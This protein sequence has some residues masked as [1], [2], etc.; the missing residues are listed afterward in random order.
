MFSNNNNN[1]NNNHNGNQFLGSMPQQQ[2]QQ[3]QQNYIQ[4]QQFNQQQ[5]QH[6]N[7]MF[8][9]MDNEASHLHHHQQQQFNQ[10]GNNTSSSLIPSPLPL[11][12]P[13]SNITGSS[14]LCF[15][16]DLQQNIFSPQSNIPT[17]MEMLSNSGNSL[18]SGLTMFSNLNSSQPI[19]M[20]NSGSNHS[21]LLAINE[22][23]SEQLV[24]ATP[25]IIPTIN[26]PIPPPP[27]QQQ[28]QQQQQV[29]LTNNNNNNN[30]NNND[31]NNDSDNEMNVEQPSSNDKLV[32]VK[33]IDLSS[34][35][36]SLSEA[37]STISTNGGGGGG[38]IHIKKRRYIIDQ[39]HIF[40]WTPYCSNY[41]H[42]IVS[43]FGTE[44]LPPTL[45]ILAEKGFSYSEVDSSWVYYRR[46]H[47]QLGVSIQHHFTI[48]DNSRPLVEIN[49]VTYPIES[50]NIGIRGVKSTDIGNPAEEV[51][52]ELYQTNSKREKN[53]EKQP[54]LMPITN[55]NTVAIP[56]LHFRKATSNNARKHKLP[57]PQQEFFRLVITVSARYHQRDYCVMS[58]I[59]DPL[60]VRT[61][62]PTLT[63]GSLSSTTKIS[64]KDNNNNNSNSNNNTTST[65]N[66]NTNSTSGTPSGIPTPEEGLSSPLVLQQQ[67]QFSPL[68]T[69]SSPRTLQL[70][71]TTT[72]NT[73]IFTHSQHHHSPLIVT[74]SPLNASSNQIPPP[75]S[76][77][78]P[79][80]SLGTNNNNNNHNNVTTSTMTSPSSP[81]TMLK[82]HQEESMTTA[83]VSSTS[84]TATSAQQQQ[85][86]IQNIYHSPPSSSH[87]SPDQDQYN[88]QLQQ[89]QQQQI[90]LQQQQFNTTNYH[91]LQQQIIQQQN[92][93]PS[94][95]TTDVENDSPPTIGTTSTT[96]TNNNNNIEV[97]GQWDQNHRGGIYRYGNVGINNAEPNE[98]LSVHG[99]IAVTG[100]TY[101]PSDRRVKKD[102]KPVNTK[103]QLEKIKKLQLYDYQL[104]DQWAK[105]TGIT[106]K[107][108]RGVL[109]QELREVIPN[110]VKETGDRELSD[111]TVLK[112]FLM[113]NKD[114]IFMENVGATQELS[115]KVDNVCIELDILDKKKIEVLGNKVG[116]L[117]QQTIREIEKNRKRKKIFITVG[118]ITVFLILSL[119][120]LSAILGTLK[121]GI[122]DVNIPSTGGFL[123]TDSSCD[124][125]LCNTTATTNSTTTNTASATTHGATTTTP[126]TT[127]TDT[128]TGVDT[129]TATA[130]TTA[131]PTTTTGLSTIVSSVP[132]DMATTTDQST[133][134]SLSQHLLN[135][136][137]GT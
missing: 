130:T 72:N 63:F 116:E 103:E 16:Q 73:P 64:S 37:T 59:S 83:N 135:L 118:I 111:G 129:T 80:F 84:S 2:Q 13:S 122:G 106:E 5:Q 42:R 98:A 7:N 70:T 126:T 9:K 93:T 11:S 117:E 134:I 69:H 94:S 85:T 74:R 101:N 56:R 109:A 38:G 88:Q 90:I 32:G 50:L 102:I 23:M 19:I 136:Y 40:H 30:N 58:L 96:T 107:K 125:A 115:K 18:F 75:P 100:T 104:T 8:I 71:P 39:N 54:P 20:N 97:N 25:I 28:Q 91:P 110:A 29:S 35:T 33:R 79:L 66:N 95:S 24:K 112:D 46:N 127:A 128:T 10:H 105:D 55:C 51:E 61:G 124:S 27:P 22:N 60:I 31:D 133:L 81:L 57:N 62:H 82:N 15:L 114:A 86:I 77:Q 26:T 21:N 87:N 3:Q 131:A 6:H 4:Q 89:Q 76:Q 14:E 12:Q 121:S 1:N 47:F 45:I 132:S 123:N 17:H 48:D 53:E 119:V 34:S 67:P 49:S 52:V 113:V 137:I 65:T 68:A 41:W 92:N 108:E 36:S 44:L 120:A 43:P 78:L 99:N